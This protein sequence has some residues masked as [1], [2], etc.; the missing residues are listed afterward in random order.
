VRAD[1]HLHHC[2]QQRDPTPRSELER[3]FENLV[4]N[5]P[6]VVV[7]LDVVQ[8]DVF[9]AER[10]SDARDATQLAWRL[11]SSL[12][13]PFSVGEADEDQTGS[14]YSASSATPALP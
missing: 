8:P 14:L 1:E 6:G 7:Y 9:V 4:E 3:R 10:L 12:R 11:A 13:A 5:I 2:G